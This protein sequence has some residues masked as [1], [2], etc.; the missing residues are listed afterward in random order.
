MATYT[1][2]NIQP[3]GKLSQTHEH[4]SPPKFAGG[5]CRWYRDGAGKLFARV[6]QHARY[7]PDGEI[8]WYEVTN[9]DSP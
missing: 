1:V 7:H 3:G 8:H 4:P 5:Q 2:L 6:T 9:R